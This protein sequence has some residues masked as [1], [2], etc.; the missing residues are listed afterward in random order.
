LAAIPN[1]NPDVVEFLLEWWPEG[2][3]AKND[4]EQ[5]PLEQY[6]QY[7]RHSSGSPDPVEL[8]LLC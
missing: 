5:T 6:R 7:R 2:K 3:Q 4:D 8:L 1:G